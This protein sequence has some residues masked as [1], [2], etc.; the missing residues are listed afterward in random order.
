M[1]TRYFRDNILQE[2]DIQVFKDQWNRK[3]MLKA[4]DNSSYKEQLSLLGLKERKSWD[5]QN[6]ET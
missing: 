5:I 6:L 2:I 3:N 4:V 1:R